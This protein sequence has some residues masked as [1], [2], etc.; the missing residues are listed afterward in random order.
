MHFLRLVLMKAFLRRATFREYG[1]SVWFVD[2]ILNELASHGGA[3]SATDAARLSR[4]S[5]SRLRHLFTPMAGMNFR[6]ARLHARVAPACD[7]LVQTDLSIPE[8]AARLHYSDRT[9]FEKA[10]K[11]VYGMTPTQYRRRHL[12]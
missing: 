4:R 10:F 7:A 11:R 5:R 8:I 2:R 1:M 6:T 3:L 9:K 12:R